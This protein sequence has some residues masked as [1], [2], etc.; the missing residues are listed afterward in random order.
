MN[1]FKEGYYCRRQ[2]ASMAIIN[3]SCAMHTQK[4]DIDPLFRPQLFGREK[5]KYYCS[6]NVTDQERKE[7]ERYT[8]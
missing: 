8:L 2:L 7:I 1:F 5:I 4:A 6:E 3:L